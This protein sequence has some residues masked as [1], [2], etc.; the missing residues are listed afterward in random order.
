MPIVLKTFF[1]K[2][3]F[4]LFVII[5][6]SC[7]ELYAQ[8]DN[9]TK[10]VFNDY[11]HTFQLY[12]RDEKDSAS[13]TISGYYTSEVQDTIIC[14]CFK[15]SNMIYENTLVPKISISN[16]YFSFSNK[17]H[18]EM[19]L[20]RFDLL[21]KNGTEKLIFRRDSIICGD[22][23]VILGQS[24]AHTTN[25][26]A[27]FSSIYCR[28]FGS[29][30]PN[31]NY[32]VY[33]EKDTSWG[34]SNAH[35]FGCRFCGEYMVG[36][37]GLKLQQLILEK[38]KIPTCIINGGT[39]GSKIEE[40][41]K[42]EKNPFNLSSAYGKLL[43]RTLKSGT[44]DKIKA[45]FWYQGEANSDESWINYE[46]NFNKLYGSLKHDFPSIK[47]IYMFQTRPGCDGDFQSE[48][49][50]TQR[51]ISKEYPDI[52]I[53]PTTGIEYH[54]GCHYYLSGYFQIAQLLFSILENDFF[55]CD[56][57]KKIL[58]PDIKNVSYSDKDSKSIKLIFN[59]KLEKM[60]END[61]AIIKNY[62]YTFPFIQVPDS[63]RQ[64]EDTILLHYAKTNYSNR[65]SYLPNKYY[66]NTNIIYEGPFFR[67][68]NRIGLL[69]FIENIELNKTNNYLVN[70][71]QIDCYPNPAK[72]KFTLKLSILKSSWVKIKITD[73]S[74]R[75]IKEYNYYEM[76]GGTYELLVSLQSVSSGV[77][78]V[79]VSTENY[80]ATKKI[81]ILK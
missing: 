23:F 47:K 42:D 34:L 63:I 35:G 67:D 46:A 11:P 26:S 56:T 41:L 28:S 18:A 73:L 77:Y 81:A 53:I 29:I 50:N 12:P 3:L 17:I 80:S 20:Y 38:Y 70:H 55:N 54:D 58:I 65:I 72:D 40:N 27:N 62:F 75:E 37:W 59:Q 79:T 1:K 71:I 61:L 36:V 10:F 24:N 8:N 14:R 64:S 22:V 13:V 16:K 32:D 30:T 69:S 51:V 21:L 68:D 45:I 57:C 74:G 2:F 44:A 25:D 60:K 48:L 33:E 39:G 78:F 5:T 9:S 19:N 15:N 31:G 76:S 4:L 66:N 43:Y 52:Q 49:R 7:R 6:G